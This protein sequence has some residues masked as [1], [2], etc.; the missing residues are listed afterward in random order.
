MR[1]KM[2]NENF[3]QKLNILFGENIFILKSNYTLAGN[4]VNIL[5]NTCKNIFEITA[6]DFTKSSKYSRY[7]KF[8]PKCRPNK[9]ASLTEIEKEVENLSLGKMEI[10]SYSGNTRDSSTLK[11][12]VC[13]NTTQIAIHSYRGNCNKRKESSKTWGCPTC[14]KKKHKTTEEFQN[15]LFNLYSGNII[16]IGEYK[17][18]ATRVSLKCTKCTYI[19]D[20]PPSSILGGSQCPNC[21]RRFRDSRQIRK[22]INILENNS[23]EYEREVSFEGLKYKKPLY[24][25]F[26]V[27]K[28][29]KYFLIEFDGQQHFR[30]WQGDSESLTI[31][32]KRDSIKNNF[33]KKYDIPLL[34]L[35]YKQT[36]RDIEK[37]L[38]GYL[39]HFKLL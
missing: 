16:L 33:C 24:F 7:L 28:D 12:K 19:W 1:P 3:Q 4:K 15:D 35:N 13:N 6:N 39:V 5:H 37:E 27:E 8:C 20:T 9:A 25:D 29:G 18:V 11:C 2:N 34:R 32:Q 26:C 23:V 30:G 22:I 21:L 14:S 38:I 17:N 10:I 36:L 31:T